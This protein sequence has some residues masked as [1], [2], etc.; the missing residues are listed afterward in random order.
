MFCY[1]VARVCASDSRLMMCMCT[2]CR[3]ESIA[4]MGQSK[5]SSSLRVHGT[6]SSSSSSSSMVT[7]SDDER[8]I[9]DF[10]RCFHQ[11]GHI[12]QD[13]VKR[14]TTRSSS[15]DK[16]H[17]SRLFNQ[18]VK[19]PIPLPS[20]RGG[21]SAGGS[22]SDTSAAAYSAPLLVHALMSRSITKEMFPSMVHLYHYPSADECI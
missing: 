21:G 4:P 8:L 13:D 19:A 1:C 18:L 6:A 3:R 20:S 9:A 11:Y 16:V 2:A 14:F 5:S 7:M 17:L 15:Y 22:S 12:N 10:F